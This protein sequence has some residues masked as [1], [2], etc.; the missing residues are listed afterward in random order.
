MSNPKH[1]LFDL[2]QAGLPRRFSV[3]TALLIM[4]LYALL[5][6]LL[7]VLGTPSWLVAE[8]TLLI[9]AVGFSQMLLFGGRN[10]RGASMIA[11][12][13]FTPLLLLG[14]VVHFILSLQDPSLFFSNMGEDFRDAWMFVWFGVALAPWAGYGIGSLIGGVFLFF[15]RD[16][17]AVDA[18]EGLDAAHQ[19][20]SAD[21]DLAHEQAIASQHPLENTYECNY[22]R[23]SVLPITVF[24]VANTLITLC[25][26]DQY[27]SL[28]VATQVMILAGFSY[29]MALPKIFPRRVSISRQ[30]VLLPVACSFDK[31]RCLS[32]SHVTLLAAD[33][34]SLDTVADKH[35]QVKTSSGEFLI[36][37]AALPSD[38]HFQ[39][40]ATLLAAVVEG[41]ENTESA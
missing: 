5:F 21:G 20:S 6:S 27:L 14:H 36:R 31:L 18:E 8:V 35:I 11:A 13:V 1:R 2:A 28:A 34:V 24:V 33:I 38:R 39:E 9:T 3:G 25:F 37:R 23:S 32:V 41:S 17:V 7:T 10:P 22:G 29:A 26:A 19:P 16:Q 15:T 4:T 40:V 12:M 30:S